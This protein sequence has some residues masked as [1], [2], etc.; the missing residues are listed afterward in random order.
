MPLRMLQARGRGRRPKVEVV[1]WL[2]ALYQ[3]PP[4]VRAGD[5]QFHGSLIWLLYLPG[6]TPAGPRCNPSKWVPHRH[7]G[8][9]PP[10]QGLFTRRCPG[11]C[12]LAVV[13]CHMQAPLGHT[14]RTVGFQVPL[15]ETQRV[16]EEPIDARDGRTTIALTRKE[17]WL[18]GR[19]NK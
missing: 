5:F 15:E 12:L 4:V 7:L 11:C 9:C 3:N 17:R 6:H 18:D 14:V 19:Q 1:S 13:L 8:L 16:Q 2:H 10:A